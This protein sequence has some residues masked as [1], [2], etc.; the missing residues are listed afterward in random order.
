MTTHP[1]RFHAVNAAL[2]AGSAIAL[3]WVFHATRIDLALE[4]PYY[5]ARSGTFPL[6]Y[7]WV[8]N[9]LVRHYVKDALIAAGIGTWIVALATLRART[10]FLA[11]HRRRW[12]CVAASF[13]AVPTVVVLLQR[14]GPMHCPWDIDTFGGYAPYR[15]LWTA[16]T[17][18]RPDPRLGRCVP[19]AFVT[20]GA[21]T[22]ACALLWWPE[23]K[24]MSVA[25]GIALFVAILAYGWVQ[26]FRGAHFLSHTLWSLWVAWVT[27]VA[28]HAATGAWREGAVDV[29]AR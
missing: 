12:W 19:A 15:D 17:T 14:V 21:W 28:L 29:E 9:V 25:L 1:G 13:V 2:L 22:M 16:I 10:G 18:H 6:R 23:R 27:I 5:D 7:D 26:Q 20:S 8:M 11:T 3:L 24:G 4:A